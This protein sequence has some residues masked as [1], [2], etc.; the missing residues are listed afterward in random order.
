MNAGAAISSFSVAAPIIDLPAMGQSASG[1]RWRLRE[2]N[3][4]TA[5]AI[6]DACRLDPVL[7]RILA[8]RGI[9]E[10]DAGAYLKPSLREAMPDPNVLTDMEQACARLAKAIRDGETI[11][12]FGDYDVDG[13]TAAAMLKLYFDAIGVASLIYLP[14]RI[15]EGYGPS[16]EA[17]RALGQQGASVIVTVDCGAAAHVPIE[18]AAKDGIDI[19]VFDHHQMSSPAPEGAVAVVNPNRPDDLSGLGGLSAA[20]VVFMGLAALN[21]ALL[22]EGFFKER[23]EPSH[24]RAGPESARRGRESGT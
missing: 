3:E 4:A 16:A 8:A 23:Q 19:V 6:A 17:F 21:R 13:A 9:S 12:V 11:G 5:A 18:E 20:G 15:T 7:A 2:A 24:G 1:R 10:A 14:D 22:A